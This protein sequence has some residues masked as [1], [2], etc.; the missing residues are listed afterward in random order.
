L[1]RIHDRQ[2]H[3]IIAAAE[4]VDPSRRA[5]RVAAGA[6]AAFKH[7]FLEVS[8]AGIESALKEAFIAA[9]QFVREANHW[10]ERGDRRPVRVGLAVVSLAGNDLFVALAPPGQIVIAQERRLCAFPALRTWDPRYDLDDAALPAE[11]LGGQEPVSPFL[12]SAVVSPDDVIVVGP[13]LLGR[14]LAA[15]TAVRPA[16]ART[17]TLAERIHSLLVATGYD[18]I[19][20]LSLTVPPVSP[21][22]VPAPA[23]DPGLAPATE[24]P[25]PGLVER[26]Y[27][28]LA[29]AVAAVT[30]SPQPA[31]HDGFSSDRQ[32]DRRSLRSG[33]AVRPARI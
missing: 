2:G 27:G 6:L 14:A 3:Q 30:A 11:P 8:S 28:G 31:L 12:T 5:E 25:R 13:S 4:P 32:T 24:R 33:I 22:T 10:R 18:G 20:V 26:L 21:E 1:L 23:T 16:Q 17:A 7:G 15:A 29:D 19:N 9:D